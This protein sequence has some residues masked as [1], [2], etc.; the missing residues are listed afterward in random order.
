MEKYSQK[1]RKLAVIAI[2]VIAV[3]SITLANIATNAQLGLNNS[4]PHIT[5][6]PTSTP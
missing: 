6:T 2:G 5:S 3:C 4:Q 1:Q